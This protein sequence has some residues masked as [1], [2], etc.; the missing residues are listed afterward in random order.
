[1][2]HPHKKSDDLASVCASAQEISEK[3]RARRAGVD[4]RRDRSPLPPGGAVALLIAVAL[5]V[6]FGAG[7]VWGIGAVIGWLGAPA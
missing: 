5:L 4:P 7:L 6:V 2:A 3:M 1:M